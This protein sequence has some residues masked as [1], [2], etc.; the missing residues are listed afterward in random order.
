[1]DLSNLKRK[2]KKRNFDFWKDLKKDA[3][4][5]IKVDNFYITNENFRKINGELLKVN[6]EYMITFGCI[7]KDDWFNPKLKKAPSNPHW[8]F[9]AFGTTKTNKHININGKERIIIWKWWWKR[10]G[11]EYNENA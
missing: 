10:M 8:N 2:T 4:P 9:Q 6:G 1:M 11:E 5:K 7:A 3:K